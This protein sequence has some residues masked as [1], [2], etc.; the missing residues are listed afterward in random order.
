MKMDMD[1]TGTDM[2]SP[3]L[4]HTLLESCKWVPATFILLKSCAQIF[5]MC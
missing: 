1:I 4:H 2:E 5:E 3:E